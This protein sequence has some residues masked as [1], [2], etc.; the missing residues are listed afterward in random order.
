M[1]SYNGPNPPRLSGQA[2]NGGAYLTSGHAVGE[3]AE[4]AMTRMKVFI[5]YQNTYMR[6][7]EAFGN[8]RHE[9]FTFGQV[10]PHR[11]GQLLR[12]KA[13]GVDPSRS[14]VETRVYR[15]EPAA[16]RSRVGQAACQRQIR[17]WVE[18]EGV[19]P[20]TRP[21]QYLPTAWDAGQPTAWTAREKGID[22]LIAIDMVM[23]AVKRRVRCL[24]TG[25][26]RHGPGPRHRGRRCPRQAGGTRVLEARPRL[27]REA[28][29][30]RKESLVPLAGSWRFQPRQRRA[31]LHSPGHVTVECAT[32]PRPP[33]PNSDPTLP[34]CWVSHRL[35]LDQPLGS[36]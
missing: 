33:R 34:S 35:G 25:I 8:Q 17:F 19:K 28:L 11:L 6:A 12:D 21:L 22:V 27:W 36:P 14:L 13:A 2:R 10:L 16:E 26:G 23:G 15:G 1:V 31:R 7:R 4:H 5:D 20:I 30:P 29:D 32:A 24:R 3:A 18:Q 9:P